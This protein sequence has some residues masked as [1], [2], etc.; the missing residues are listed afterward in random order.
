MAWETPFQRKIE[1]RL[2]HGDSCLP[3]LA[4]SVVFLT[5]LFGSDYFSSEKVRW[6][7]GYLASR[8]IRLLRYVHGVGQQTHQN[9]VLGLQDVYYATR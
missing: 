6:K 9:F 2:V 5:P 7:R 1:V 8:N 4:T 3:A